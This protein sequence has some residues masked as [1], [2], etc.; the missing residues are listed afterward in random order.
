[1]PKKTPGTLLRTKRITKSHS[2]RLVD[3]FIEKVLVATLLGGNCCETCA[4]TPKHIESCKSKDGYP[5]FEAALFL[6]STST[7]MCTFLLT[8][9]CCAFILREKE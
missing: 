9:V 2:V 7:T 3:C 1:M 8:S 5:I 6:Y 4:F